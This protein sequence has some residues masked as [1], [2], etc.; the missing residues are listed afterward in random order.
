MGLSHD[1]MEEFKYSWLSAYIRFITKCALFRGIQV[2]GS[3]RR[4]ILIMFT[5]VQVQC[6][7]QIYYPPNV[8]TSF[9]IYYHSLILSITYFTCSSLIPYQ[10]GIL[11]SCAD[12]FSAIGKFIVLNSLYASCLCIAI[13]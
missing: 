8:I 9:S 13:G 5:R 4:V 3:S 6:F 11:S 12:I 1:I 10:I 7:K 2:F